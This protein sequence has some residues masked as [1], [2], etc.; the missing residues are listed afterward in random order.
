M[1]LRGEASITALYLYSDLVRRGRQT[2][3]LTVRSARQVCLTSRM[4]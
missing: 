3:D 1:G 4:A 2:G